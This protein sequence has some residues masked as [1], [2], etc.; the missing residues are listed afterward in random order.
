MW[1]VLRFGLSVFD[2]RDGV[3]LHSLR[4]Y[5]LRTLYIKLLKDYLENKWGKSTL[6][7][8]LSFGE[9]SA[10]FH[11]S[12]GT[13]SQ[14]GGRR[15]LP[16]CCRFSTKFYIFRWYVGFSLEFLEISTKFL[17]FREERRNFGT[18]IT[19]SPLNP[20]THPKSGNTSH[21]FILRP[22]RD[23]P[24]ADARITSNL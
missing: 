15:F 20:A 6:T 7:L 13:D 14:I 12:W 3:L 22:K 2:F 24:Q 11:F 8:T 21:Q 9:I 4:G 5:P 19:N 10:K 23:P 16:G 1:P 18:P 17:E